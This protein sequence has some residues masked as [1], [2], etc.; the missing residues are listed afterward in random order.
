MVLVV[1]DV[2]GR[3]LHGVAGIACLA[4]HVIPHALDRLAGLAAAI[5]LLALHGV[6]LLHKR[7][8]LIGSANFSSH[9]A[10]L[11]AALHAIDQLCL[12]VEAVAQA[13]IHAVDLPLDVRKVAG[14]NVAVH[15]PKKRT[16][17]E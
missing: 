11:H 12:A 13:V 17:T 14:Q 15:R 1:D 4:C 2:S 10:L 8:L 16:G 9:K 7:S 5:C 6:Q 3:R